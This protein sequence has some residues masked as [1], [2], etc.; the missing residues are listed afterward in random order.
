MLESKEKIKKKTKKNAQ[1]IVVLKKYEQLFKK[2][3]NQKCLSQ[4]TMQICRL[5]N[6]WNNSEAGRRNGAIVILILKQNINSIYYFFNIKK[7]HKI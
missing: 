1:H 4:Q 6:L 5:Y 2:N 7:T 3:K